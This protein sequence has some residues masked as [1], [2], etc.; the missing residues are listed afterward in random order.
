[1]LLKKS[2]IH[3]TKSCYK[4]YHLRKANVLLNRYAEVFPEPQS[5]LTETSLVRG[6]DG[7]KM[8]KRYGNA[9][10]LS[11]T[12]AETEAK[13]MQM[14]T[15]PARKRRSDPG[16]PD[17]CPVFDLQKIYAPQEWV[18]RVNRE[19]RT[20][21]IGCVE[22]KQALAKHLN[23]RL[24]PFRAVRSELASDPDRVM[25]VLAEGAAM[26]RK[27]AAETMEEVRKAMLI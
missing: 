23:E 17:V 22:D 14:I 6:T 19:C 5:L 3:S 21:E 18:D 7:R 10:L 24:R 15:D 11:D 1:M 20:A 12:E 27:V 25:E 26:A 9:I 4:N 2:H 8:S 13:I 16:N